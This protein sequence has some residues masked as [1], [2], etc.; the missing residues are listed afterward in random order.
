MLRDVVVIDTPG[1]GSTYRHN[2]EVT[3]GFLPQS[4]AALFLVSVD[5]PITEVEL[6]FLKD[7]KSRVSKLFF[8]L[9]KV[10]YLTKTELVEALTFTKRY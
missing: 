5:P 3:M 4:D 8:A 1:I 6:A 10:D 2:T 7:I 9:N